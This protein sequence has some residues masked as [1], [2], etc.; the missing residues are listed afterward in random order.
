MFAEALLDAIKELL[1]VSPVCSTRLLTALQK[2]NRIYQVRVVV[3]CVYAD[4]RYDN[5]KVNTF[6]ITLCTLSLL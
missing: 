6:N 4:T 3:R 5:T 2:T 1:S